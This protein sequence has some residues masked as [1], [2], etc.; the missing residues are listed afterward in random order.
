MDEL[1]AA[2][3]GVD[4]A[5][6]TPRWRRFAALAFAAAALGFGVTLL[7]ARGRVDGTP[8]PL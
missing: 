1:A 2:L 4:G 7:R 3:D 5:R 8:A 6:R